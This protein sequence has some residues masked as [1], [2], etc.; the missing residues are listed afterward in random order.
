MYV[1]M[2]GAKARQARKEM[3]KDLQ[4]FNW[5]RKLKGMAEWLCLLLVK[6]YWIMFEGILAWIEDKWEMEIGKETNALQI[7]EVKRRKADTENLSEEGKPSKYLKDQSLMREQ[8]EELL[9][10]LDKLS[11]GR[12]CVEQEGILQTYDELSKHSQELVVPEV[13]FD[14]EEI[15]DVEE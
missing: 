7:C 4:D 3:H 5:W 12:N 14:G 15:R 11:I 8:E 1:K 10:Y 13:F 6:T 2:K 9:S